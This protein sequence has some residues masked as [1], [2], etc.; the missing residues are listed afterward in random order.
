MV[1]PQ[2]L[3][4][5]SQKVH[6]RQVQPVKKQYVT[7]P[8]HKKVVAYRINPK[9]NNKP[10]KQPPLQGYQLPKSKKAPDD[11]Y[12]TLL[13][14]FLI[15]FLSGAAYFTTLV[16]SEKIHEIKTKSEKLIQKHNK[17]KTTKIRKSKKHAVKSEKAKK[18]QVKKEESKPLT[19]SKKTTK[20]KAPKK[21]KAKNDCL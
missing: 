19:T 13:G 2:Q 11:F 17:R 4:T 8:N 16:V 10:V 14:V 20:K 15:L 12:A 21:Q 9:P 5:P 1:K 3:N 6:R 7:P 18:D